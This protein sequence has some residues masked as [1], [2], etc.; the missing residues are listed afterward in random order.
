MR[1]TLV[2]TQLKEKLIDSLI[3]CYN[4]H[5]WLLVREN[6][7]HLC[8]ESLLKQNNDKRFARKTPGFD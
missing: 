5:I 7:K 2:A 6:N 3:I 1:K 8:H 4:S